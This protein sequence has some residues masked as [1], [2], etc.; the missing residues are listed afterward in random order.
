MHDAALVRGVERVDELTRDPERLGNRQPSALQPIGERGPVDELHDE[1]RHTAL[2]FNA[3][4][5][6]DVGMV[7]RRQG[8]RFPLEALDAVAVASKCVGQ[9]L[10]RDV[11]PQSHV[12]GAVDLAHASRAERA[13]DFVAGESGAA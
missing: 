4:E 2:F 12:S 13:V 9:D 6:R 11:T 8:P 1:R 5:D 7:Q 3:V 10:E